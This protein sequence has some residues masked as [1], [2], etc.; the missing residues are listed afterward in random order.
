MRNWSTINVVDEFLVSR[1]MLR[2]KSIKDYR[3]DLVRFAKVFPRL[4]LAS[5]PIQQ[6]LNEQKRI[7]D[8]S[9]LTPETIHH[10]FRSVRAMYR[11]FW[12]WHEVELRNVPNPI[13]RIR[14]AQPKPKA[15]RIWSEQELFNIFNSEMSN[16]DRAILNLFLD[17][18]PRAGECSSLTWDDVL[19][20]SFIILRGKTGERVEPISDSTLRLILA[21][22]PKECIGKDHVFVGLQGPL[23][24]WGIYLIVRR[25]CARAGIK[26]KRT[27][28]HTFRHT[29]GTYYA[30]SEF[31]QPKV[32]QNLLGHSDFKTTQRYIN[33][34]RKQIARNHTLCTPLRVIAAVAQS[35]FLDKIDAVKAAETI[36][37]ESAT[38]CISRKPSS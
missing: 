7:K 13:N 29:F 25:I 26:G 5:Q 20:D 8:D 19:P 22:K 2:P 30:D 24:Y 35:N 15:M 38:A 4:P 37:K 14:V 32:L 11:Q 1:G 10:R 23:T 18:G 6:W 12:D 16:R 21:L 36:I 3:E 34:S 17:L 28:P 9:P 27:S 33:N 31:C